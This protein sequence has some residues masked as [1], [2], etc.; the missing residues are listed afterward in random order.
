[1]LPSL[2]NNQPAPPVPLKNPLPMH[3]PQSLPTV[4]PAL[5]AFDDCGTNFGGKTS[6]M[7]GTDAE[8]YYFTR[9]INDLIIFL[10][11]ERQ[12]FANQTEEDQTRLKRSTCRTRETMR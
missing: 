5:S 11:T 8:G 12:Y 6:Y 4:P 2:R 7:G 10:P 3:P 9:E 1:M